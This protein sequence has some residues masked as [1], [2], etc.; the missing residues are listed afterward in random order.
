MTTHT[1]HRPQTAR[2]HDAVIS[3][4]AGSALSWTV[5]PLVLAVGA[6]VD[7]ALAKQ[8][9]DLALRLPEAWS[10]F[11]AI[12]LGLLAVAGAFS[13]GMVARAGHRA[14]AISLLGVPALIA[15]ALFILRA[16]AHVFA[17][18]EVAYEGS[19]VAEAGDGELLLAWVMLLVFVATAVMAF[20]DGWKLVHPGRLRFR[21]VDARLARLELEHA[22]RV[23]R[24]IRLRENLAIHLDQLDRIDRQRDVALAEL[25]ALADELQEW[26]R[27]EIV[28]HLGDPVATSAL[29]A[30]GPT[31]LSPSAPYPQI[32]PR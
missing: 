4:R 12:G 10:W 15:V 17:P 27:L 2:D 18:A 1:D 32:A 31:R 26:A 20:F 9:F 22:D 5:H 6:A 30:A 14:P 3:S 11:V 16:F 28:R 7:I 21:A 8:A 25:A 29:H 13:A 24:V 19:T 23:G